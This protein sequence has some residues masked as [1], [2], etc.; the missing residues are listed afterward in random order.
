MKHIK[1]LFK[2]NDSYLI[3]ENI[4]DARGDRQR[5]EGEE[6]GEEP[7]G[8]IHGRVETLG[9]KMD[10]QLWELLLRK[11]KEPQ[12]TKKMMCWRYK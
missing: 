11:R 9:S 12:I 4:E 8:G 6:K 10:V 3:H 1:Y 5:E 7:G 2:I